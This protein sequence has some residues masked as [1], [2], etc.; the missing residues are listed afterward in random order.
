MIDTSDLNIGRTTIHTLDAQFDYRRE[1]DRAGTFDLQAA[2]T[3]HPVFRRT[4]GSGLPTLDFKNASDGAL[5]LRGYAGVEW[6]RD[7]FSLALSGQ[8]LGSYLVTSANAVTGDLSQ[9][10]DL[11]SQ[12][13]ARIPAQATLDLAVHYAVRL[14]GAGVGERPRTL[15]LRF[16]V[17]DLL[18]CRAPIVVNTL[19]GNSN[20]ADPRRRRFELTVAAGL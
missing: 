4:L 11:V 7:T 5:S 19:G 15:E 3:W 14:P 10:F 6:S 1:T 18:D 13:S 2:A 20:Y 12:G 9:R 17:Q 16:G 8:Y